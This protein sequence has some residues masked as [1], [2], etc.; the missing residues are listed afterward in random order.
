MEAIQQTYNPSI[1]YERE[2]LWKKF[3]GW[4]TAQDENRYGWLAAALFGHGCIFA[5][6]TLLVSMMAGVHMIF[7]ALVIASMSA[8][9]VSNLAAMPTRY[10][11]P[12]FFGSLL[13]NLGVLIASVVMIFN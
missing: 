10:T 6:I 9:L 12:I 11:L 4:C 2:N 1:N 8:V 13:I 5:P 3:I 7:F